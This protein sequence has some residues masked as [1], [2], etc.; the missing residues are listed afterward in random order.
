MSPLRCALLL[1]GGW[2]QALHPLAPTRKFNLHSR[3][4]A[5]Q[6]SSG[7]HAFSSPLALLGASLTAVRSDAPFTWCG[8]WVFQNFC[9]I[10][11]AMS[12]RFSSSRGV[13][14]FLN[15]GFLFSLAPLLNLHRRVLDCRSI[16][17]HRQDSS[18]PLT[19]N[20]EPHASCRIFLQKKA[21]HRCGSGQQIQ[22]V[23]LC[24]SISSHAADQR[25]RRLV[26]S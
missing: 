16:Q 12:P 20:R 21:R 4:C 15:L 26:G 5:H 9:D 18:G 22:V 14:P 19:A 2:L 25:W 10:S 23:C 1:G 3:L 13:N 24:H 7:S 6:A 8:V 11:D 17:S